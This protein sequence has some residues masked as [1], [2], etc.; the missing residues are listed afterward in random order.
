MSNLIT[1]PTFNFSQ[2]D[3]FDG[4]EMPVTVC[5]YKGSE[6]RVMI[7][8]MQEDRCIIFTSLTELKALVKQIE[9]HLPEATKKLK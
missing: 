9:K 4:N 7:E 8:L 1:V 2:G 5:Y 6:N 3:V